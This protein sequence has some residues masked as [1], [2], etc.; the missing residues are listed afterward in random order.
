MESKDVGQ[1]FGWREWVVL[2]TLLINFSTFLLRTD[3]RP[4]L[5]NGWNW[6]Y[7]LSACVC[8]AYLIDRY[9]RARRWMGTYK[10]SLN[11]FE[12]N[13]RM[14]LDSVVKENEDRLRIDRVDWARQLRD[15]IDDAV[16]Y[17]ANLAT[18]EKEHNDR[19]E[20]EAI[21]NKRLDEISGRLPPIGA[22]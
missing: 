22:S 7:L 4:I 13:L 17:K 5:L 18:V 11:A 1:R 15:L 8:G 21:I 2:L 10:S 12:A 20:A 19:I 3:I 16:Q 6:F 14:S 9:I